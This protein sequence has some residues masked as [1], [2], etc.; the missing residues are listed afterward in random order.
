MSR[1]RCAT[2]DMI[3]SCILKFADELA[4]GS[5]LGNK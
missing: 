3:M 2:R 1:Y 5:A 4:L